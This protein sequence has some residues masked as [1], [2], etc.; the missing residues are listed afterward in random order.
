MPNVIKY[1]RKL[2]ITV[3]KY[4]VLTIRSEY[5]VCTNVKISYLKGGLVNFFAAVTTCEMED[6]V[7]RSYTS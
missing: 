6:L 3:K 5:S 1:K 4:S 2:F 7:V